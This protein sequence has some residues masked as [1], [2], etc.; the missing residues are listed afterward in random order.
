MKTF[1]QDYLLIS[2]IET[3]VFIVLLIASMALMYWLDKRGTKYTKIL[4]GAVG[5]GT[6]IGL[7]GYFSLGND[8]NKIGQ[9]SSI[10]KLIGYGYMD[11]LKMI[12][13][14]LVFFSMIRV[15]MTTKSDFKRK[16]GKV[17]GLFAFTVTISALITIL[18]SISIPNAQLLP[19]AEDVG[20]TIRE[21]G[22]FVSTVRSMIP[23]NVVDIFVKGNMIAIVVLA[24]MIGFAVKSFEDKKE[25]QVMID[26][27]EGSFK[28]VRQLTIMI[29]DLMPYALI[30]LLAN[31]LL[32]QG[33]EALR[34]AFMFIVVLYVAMIL[35]FLFHL[36]LVKLT[37]RNIKAYLQAVREP[38]LLAFT[39]RSSLG[40]LPVTID[41]MDNKLK[42]QN[43]LSDLVGSFGTTMGMNG[44]AGVYPTLVVVALASAL[45]IPMDISFYFT[46]LI[47]VVLG[48]FGIAGIPGAATMSVAVVLTGMGMVEYYPLLG[49]VLAIDPILDMGRTLLNVHGTLTVGVVTDWLEKRAG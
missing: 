21:V 43:G 42:L 33:E 18:I 19:P 49:A 41:A 27:I 2:N 7:L 15:V 31:V 34:G 17:I 38:L 36:L 20:G 48:S 29:M 14:P 10:Y 5:L 30:P 26:F 9:I 16:V 45:Q 11:L 28:I 47:V 12:A 37:G 35:V 25:I 32:T 23:N 24:F 46:L 1:L 8:A 44:C 4:L 39:S 13:L 22:T 3:V 40:T 6:V